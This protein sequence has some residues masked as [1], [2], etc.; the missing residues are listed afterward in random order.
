MS[1]DFSTL[2]N[3]ERQSCLN[4]ALSPASPGGV[5]CLNRFRA[6]AGGFSSTCLHDGERGHVLGVPCC[7]EPLFLG[8]MQVL[9]KSPKT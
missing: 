3:G 5:R 8:V 6:V 7:V 2:K 4:G 1:R 9:Q